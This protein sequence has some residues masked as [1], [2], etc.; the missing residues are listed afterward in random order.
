MKN[1]I[2]YPRRLLVPVI[3]FAVIASVSGLGFIRF[4]LRNTTQRADRSVHNQP[5]NKVPVDL[6]AMIDSSRDQ[7]LSARVIIRTVDEVQPADREMIAE[8]GGN[9]THEFEGIHSVLAQMP[10]MKIDELSKQDRV[11]FITPDREV[12]GAL[13]AE[14]RLLGVDRLRQSAPSSLGGSYSAVDGTGIGIAILDTGINTGNKDLNKF[15]TNNSRIVASQDCLVAGNCVAGKAP[16]S[17]SNSS[18]SFGHGTSVAGVAAGNGWASQQKDSTGSLWYPTTYGNYT[19]I[20]PNA[21]ILS[22]R[23]L[24]ENGAA[25]ISRVIDAINYVIWLKSRASMPRTTFA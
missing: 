8:L 22:I 3:A 16:G 5:V 9:V 6:R 21:N 10:L 12:K 7:N 15:G 4:N 25:P 1:L 13:A 17:G 18:D 23:V 14:S 20:A 11:Q 24:D 19:G 2:T